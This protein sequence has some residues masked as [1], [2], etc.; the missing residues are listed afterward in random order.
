FSCLTFAAGGC[1]TFDPREA[2][3]CITYDKV[4]RRPV[5]D[6]R[7]ERFIGKVDKDT[8]RCRGGSEAVDRRNLPCVDW[9]N[10]WAA[11]D[12]T[13]KSWGASDGS[14]RVTPN[15]RGILGALID[16]EY[17][18]ME[19]IK[20][21]LFDN[22][23]TYRDYVLGRDGNKGSLL[24]TWT[25]MRLPS[26]HEYYSAVGGDGMQR[27]QGELIRFRTLSGICN[28]IQNP[29]MWS[30]NQPFARNVEFETTFPDLKPDYPDSVERQVVRNR[31][32]NRL[33]K[34]A[35]HPAGKPDPQVISRKL[36]TRLSPA[37]RTKSEC[38]KPDPDQNYLKAP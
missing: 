15:G 8:A 1:A 26:T 37:C 3:D 34:D 11:G 23:G 12:A 6:Q 7:T 14:G 13:S 38:Y 21:N 31:H 19:L 36:F 5:A 17:Q 33:D 35:N 10:Y 30:T 22:S 27:C 25:S 29:L 9:Q 28:D 4:W 2:I 20:F 32:A 24:K 16:L 18:R